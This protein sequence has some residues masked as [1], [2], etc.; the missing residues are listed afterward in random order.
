MKIEIYTD[1]S[2]RGNPGPGGW[3]AVI[4][5]NDKQITLAEQVEF[6]T[7]QRM[8]LIAAIESLNYVDEQTF[9]LKNRFADDIVLYTD[10]AY[11]H[12][13]WAKGWWENWSRNGWKNAKKEAVANQDLWEKLIP[14]FRKATFTIVKVKGHASNKYNNLADQLATGTIQPSH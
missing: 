12:N 11:L 13:C 3:G 5:L 8:E 4:F 14:W 9:S 1:G 2:C 7:N 6:T 10:S